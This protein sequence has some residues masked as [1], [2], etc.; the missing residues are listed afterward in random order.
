MKR[1]SLFLLFLPFSISSD[2]HL[3]TIDAFNIT[4]ISPD[5]LMVS[6]QSETSDGTFY[7]QMNRP[8]CLCEEVSF[9]LPTPE[10]KDFER[11]KEDSYIE[12]TM[13]IDF[14]K[15]KQIEYEVWLAREDSSENIIIPQGPFPSIREAKLINIDTPYGRFRF[16]LEGFKDAM[17]QA[18]KMCESWIP[19]EENKVEAIDA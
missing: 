14:K 10:S 6:K 13:R 2:I 4:S 18:T 8:Y 9:I 17:R 1:I 7:F 11:P 15:P 16:I 3:T 12:G 5:Y 19:Y